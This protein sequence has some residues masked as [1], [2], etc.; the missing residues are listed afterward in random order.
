M[1]NADDIARTIEPGSLPQGER[2]V[3]AGNLQAALPGGGVGG[4][5]A[6]AVP[7]APAPGIDPIERLLAGDHETDLPVT[8][9]IS[10]GPGNTGAQSI[11]DS[12]KVVKLRL[13]AENAK[14]PVIRYQ[15]RNALRR[16]LSNGGS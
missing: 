6:P 14:S 11:N 7:H 13:L 4:S 10:Q 2:Q 16:E 1:P 15:A 12:P 9:G 8:S 3:V 5:P